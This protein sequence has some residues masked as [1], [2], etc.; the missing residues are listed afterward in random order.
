LRLT[1]TGLP[2]INETFI[3]FELRSSVLEARDLRQYIPGD[4]YEKVQKFGHIDLSGKFLGFPNDFVA[5]GTF[6]TRLGRII[7]DVNLKLKENSANSTYQ[8][9]LITYGFN[10]G[11]L[12]DQPENLQLLDMNGRIKGKGFAIKDAAVDMNATINRLGIRDYNYRNI[13]V[14]GKL[15][16]QRFIGDLAVKD[17]NLVFTAN[18]ELDLRNG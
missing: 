17:T 8:G 5:N 7:S 6:D 12:L 10:I 18:G 13:K 9:K 3:D 15:S 2:S 16:R 11:E 1:L 4:A 14:N